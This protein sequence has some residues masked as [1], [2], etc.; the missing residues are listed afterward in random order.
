MKVR[1]PCINFHLQFSSFADYCVSHYVLRMY[2]IELEENE[3]ACRVLCFFFAFSTQFRG[4][5]YAVNAII[6]RSQSYISYEI[7]VHPIYTPLYLHG[8]I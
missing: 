4:L 2:W 1:I 5:S 7:H 3:S 8:C 6:H